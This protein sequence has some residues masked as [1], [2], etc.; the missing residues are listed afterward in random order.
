MPTPA[1]CAI[2]AALAIVPLHSISDILLAERTPVRNI[3]EDQ[4]ILPY[5][6]PGQ[7]LDIGG[8]RINLHCTGAGSPTV[9]LMAGI[10][11]WSVVWYKTQPVIA[12]TT[13]ICAFDRAKLR[14]ARRIQV[15]SPRRVATRH[16]KPPIKPCSL[17]P[18]PIR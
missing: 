11:S 6:K 13:R 17:V 1:R 18:C 10:F 5:A 14:V 16:L 8:R 12:Q 2:L 7:L 15:S 4:R 9:I 3:A